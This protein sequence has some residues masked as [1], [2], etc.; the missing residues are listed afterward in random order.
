M[1]IFIHPPKCVFERVSDLTQAI[2]GKVCLIVAEV[3]F[4]EAASLKQVACQT[5]AMKHSSKL[6]TSQ[7]ACISLFYKCHKPLL[8]V[9]C[10]CTAI[11]IYNL[12][13]VLTKPK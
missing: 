12:Q 2:E 9:F 8:K 6:H 1:C 5:L 13:N 3:R 11:R 4:E 10:V 7:Q